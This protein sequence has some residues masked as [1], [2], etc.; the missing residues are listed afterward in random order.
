MGKRV[1]VCRRATGQ[2]RLRVPSTLN[3]LQ[4]RC[5]T[6]SHEFVLPSPTG[7]AAG[8]ARQEAR[9]ARNAGDLAG[10]WISQLVRWAE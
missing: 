10:V 5:T 2:Q 9:D 4:V 6:C 1:I 3:R 8:S 7:D